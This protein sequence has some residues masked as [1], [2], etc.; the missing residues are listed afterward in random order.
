[1][2]TIKITTQADRGGN[3][4]AIEKMVEWLEK[5]HNAGGADYYMAIRKVRQL[6]YE[7]Q[8]KP[9]VTEPCPLSHAVQVKEVEPLAIAASR[10]CIEIMP[11]V[12]KGDVWDITLENAP[13][14]RKTFSA[15]TYAACE[16]QARKWLE[17]LED[18]GEG[19]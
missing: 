18:K 4:T 5:A 11:P 1:M 19:I 17:E 16:S 15:P 14:G 13:H 6:A 8:S 2:K 12:C 10:F 9:T 7:E 3:M